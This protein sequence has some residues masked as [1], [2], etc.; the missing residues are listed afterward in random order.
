MFVLRSFRN[1]VSSEDPNLF[2]GITISEID[3]K[4]IEDTEEYGE[5]YVFI[6]SDQEEGG[7][8][9][10]IYLESQSIFRAMKSLECT[11]E[12]LNIITGTY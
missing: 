10:D 9:N 1:P 8:N 12:E 2:T 6:P 7:D 4:I 11:S 3:E 5:E